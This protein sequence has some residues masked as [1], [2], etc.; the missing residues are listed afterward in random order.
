MCYHGTYPASSFN[1]IQIE[2]FIVFVMFLEWILYLFLIVNPLVINRYNFSIQK[3]RAIYW[4]KN[5]IDIL[6][7]RIIYKGEGNSG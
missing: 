1:V 7:L 4:Y 2:L 3:I 5:Q 6:Q